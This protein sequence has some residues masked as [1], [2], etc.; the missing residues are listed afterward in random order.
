MKL[1]SLND[2]FIILASSP[3]KILPRGIKTW[4]RQFLASNEKK[5]RDGQELLPI[6]QDLI[7]GQLLTPYICLGVLFLILS[8]AREKTPGDRMRGK[9]I[10]M[11]HTAS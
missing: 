11:R 4:S 6:G 5:C 3:S 10:T 8:R 9:A 7:G 2:A 1:F